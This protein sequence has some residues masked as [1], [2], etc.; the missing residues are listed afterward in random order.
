M[1]YAGFMPCDMAESGRRPVEGAGISGERDMESN[2]SRE[3]AGAEGFANERYQ[4]GEGYCKTDFF[5][6]HIKIA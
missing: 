2:R 6:P 5:K 3:R 4:P 1:L